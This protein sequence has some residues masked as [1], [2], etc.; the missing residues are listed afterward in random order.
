VE[1][2]RQANPTCRFFTMTL[3]LSG[4][5]CWLKDAATK[6]ESGLAD[7]YISGAKEPWSYVGVRSKNTIPMAQQ[8]HDLP[9]L[10]AEVLEHK[11]ATS[12]RTP[13]PKW[14]GLFPHLGKAPKFNRFKCTYDAEDVPYFEHGRPANLT[15]YIVLGAA[16]TGYLPDSILG[17]GWL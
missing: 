15:S 10:K 5:H 7:T 8:L 16:R 12:N 1:G 4:S 11:Q 3:A 2:A 6:L 9:S 14:S 13:Q 17:G